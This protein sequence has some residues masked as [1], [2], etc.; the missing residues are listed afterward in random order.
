MFG[1]NFNRARTICLKNSPGKLSLDRE[2]VV[3]MATALA[4]LQ[5][6]NLWFS[7]TKFTIGKF[8]LNK[9]YAYSK[10]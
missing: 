10:F 4:I 1:S 9:M 2:V 5:Y 8:L 7:V 3:K 6:P